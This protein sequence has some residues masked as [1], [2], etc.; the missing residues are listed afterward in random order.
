MKLSDITVE[1]FIKI[2]QIEETF[3]EDE[4]KMSVEIAKL[5]FTNNDLKVKDLKEFSDKLKLALESEPR[6]IQRFEHNGIEYG[7]IPNLEELTTGEYIDLDNYQRN[8]ETYHKMLSILY[9]PIVKSYGK[10][11]QIEKYEGTKYENE[12]K[13]VS[14][15]ILLGSLQFFFH[16]L[17]I[18]HQ[19][20]LTYS[21]VMMIK[22]MKKP[23]IS[24]M[25]EDS[26]NDT[27]G[28][29]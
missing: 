11:Y 22:M 27:I 5:F 21:Q 13:N 3:K 24:Q 18:M 2:T 8:K 6:F 25:K 28:I 14:C 4:T 12:M 10:L 26:M 19:D 20:S 9:R 29:V 1:Q 7:F 17:K 16:L 23:L 15:E